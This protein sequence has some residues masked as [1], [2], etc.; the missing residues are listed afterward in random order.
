[1]CADLEALVGKDAAD[2]TQNDER[3]CAHGDE[4]WCSGIEQ[5]AADV[6]IHCRS[7]LLKNW[8]DLHRFGLNSAPEVGIRCSKN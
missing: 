6:S 5:S 3:Q 7:A 1:M 8:C 4:V 2:R